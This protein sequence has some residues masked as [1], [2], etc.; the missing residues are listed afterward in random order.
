MNTFIMILNL[1]ITF[2]FLLSTTTT[3]LITAKATITEHR[4]KQQQHTWKS[5]PDLKRENI[6]YERFGIWTQDP[7]YWL[8]NSKSKETAKFVHEQN[9]ITSE[10][11]H[12]NENYDSIKEKFKQLYNTTTYG[13]PTKYGDKYF[14][15]IRKPEQNQAIIYSLNSLDDEPIEFL[16]PNKLSQDGTIALKFLSFSNDGKYCAYGTSK[17]GSDWTI[18]HIKNVETLE[19]LPDVLTKIKFSNVAWTNNNDGFFYAYY[20]EY[21]GDGEGTE[22]VIPEFQ[23]LYYHRLNT[24]QKNDIKILGFPEHPKWLVGSILVS[25][26]GHK[27]HLFPTEGTSNTP[28]LYAHFDPMNISQSSILF[29]WIV[30]KQQI[31]SEYHYVGDDENC[32]YVRTNYKAKN[33]RLVCVDLNNPSRDNWRDIIAESTKAILSNAYIADYDKIVAT[34]MIDVQDKLKV[35]RLLDGEYLYDIPIEIG[36]IVAAVSKM[37]SPEF[38]FLHSKF[39]SPGV[40]YYHDLSTNKTVVYKKSII[41]GFNES[42]YN[43]T[44]IFYKSKDG[45]QV[46]MF[47]VSRKNITLDGQN[48]TWLYAYGGFNINVQPSYNPMAM[49]FVKYLNGIY[50]SANIRG[51]GEYGDDWHKQGMLLNKQNV[52]D[53]FAAAGDWLIENN[54]TSREYLTI[55]GRSNGGLL[56]ATSANQRP[57]IFGSTIAEVGVLDM[58]KFPLFTIGYAW[59]EEYGDVIHNR[60]HF[61]YVQKYSPLHNVPHNLKQYPNMLVVTAD[62]DDRVV[63]AH[64]YKFIAELQYRL[65]KKLP[66]TP[67]M[68]RIDSNS[69]HGAGKPVSKWIEEYTD[70]I[71]FLLN[72]TPYKYDNQKD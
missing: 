9:K 50:A 62:H 33:F 49:F 42:D 59:K 53:D 32:T 43:N 29:K 13:I 39:L 7:Y 2:S 6:F 70:K 21:K 47:I 35:H 65:G 18:I 1:I 69:G 4:S 67:L 55:N 46:P 8:E 16:D 71:C 24:E 15:S 28:W 19:D 23:K 10:Y 12:S 44:Q 63:P 36:S 27:I 20:D 40:I 3:T 66:N 52:F 5:Y 25:E 60:T 45:T 14:V 26:D 64:S 61:K 72:S 34:Y 11:I 48:P 54:F 22:T 17:G 37:K 68:I 56:A 31:D 41:D 30:S 58:L 38:F 57:D 51:G